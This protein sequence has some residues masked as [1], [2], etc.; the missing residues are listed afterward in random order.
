MYLPTNRR[1]VFVEMWA[2]MGGMLLY[3]PSHSAETATTIFAANPPVLLDAASKVAREIE[4]RRS[5]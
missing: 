5:E 2:M 3:I 4:E 1:N